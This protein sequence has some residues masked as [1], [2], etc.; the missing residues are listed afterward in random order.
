[1]SDN[2]VSYSNYGKNYVDIFAPGDNIMTTY[3]NKSLCQMRQG[4][5]FAA[6][7]VSGVAALLL[8][9]NSRFTAKDLKDIICAPNLDQYGNM[10]SSPVKDM[11]ISGK[12][13]DAG[14][15]L[16]LAKNWR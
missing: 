13:L 14:A 3:T 1:M 7:F 16:K 9:Y 11:C 2:R 6:P 10:I 5:S 12:V 4:T 15:A 8:S